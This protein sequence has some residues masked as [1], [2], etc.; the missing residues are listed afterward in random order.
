MDT[1][2]TQKKFAEKES[3]S[4]PLYA[5]AEGKAA[6]AFGVLAGKFASRSTF[7]INKEGNIAKI[8]TKVSPATHAD[9]VVDFV[10]KNLA[11]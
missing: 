2:E 10:K 8:Y 6:K 1:L 4:Y 3:L 9:E 5:D 11:K 7:V